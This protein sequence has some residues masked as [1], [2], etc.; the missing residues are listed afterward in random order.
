MDGLTLNPSP[1]QEEARSHRAGLF[2][3]AIGLGFVSI[4][5]QVLLLRELASSLGGN[6][7]ALGLT[8]GSW[9]LW[10]GAGSLFANKIR[11][12]NPLAP[13][14]AY[15]KAG[16]LFPLTILAIRLIRPW[17]GILP[18]EAVGLLTIL[19]T[20]LMI[21]APFGFLVGALFVLLSTSFPKEG[22]NRVYLLEALGA[23]IGGV[24]TT[25]LFIPF[26][27]NLAIAFL[28][29][30]LCIFACFVLSSEH[31]LLL[32]WFGWILLPVLLILSGVLHQPL[33]RWS[34][35]QEWKGFELLEATNSPYGAITV[36]SQAEQVSVFQQGSLV[37]SY[38]DPLSA[39]EAVHF[40]LLEHPSP[41]TALLIGN[42]LGGG[43]SEALKHPAL[44]LEYVDLDPKLLSV[45]RRVLP[46]QA[47]PAPGQVRIHLA[48]PRRYLSATRD[49]YDVILLNLPVPATAQ[50]N[51][52]YTREFFTLVKAHLTPGGILAFR[53][54]SEENYLSP[55]LSDFLSSIR[56]TLRGAFP[57]VA[58]LPGGTAIFL[59]SEA[60]RVLTRNPDSLIARLRERN[61]KTA[62]VSEYFLPDRLAPFRQER[63]GAALDKAQ[64]Q[65]NT[66]AQPICYYFDALLFSSHFRSSEKA[67]VAFLSKVP[68][69]VF[70]ILFCLGL[71]I[72]LLHG[73]SSW[74][75]LA[76]VSAGFT[77]M[78]LEVLS[79]VVFQTYSGA[80]YSGIGLLLAAF[81]VGLA[82]GSWLFQRAARQTLF[83][84]KLLQGILVILPMMF[85]ILIR[86]ASAP[87]LTRISDILFPFFLGIAGIICGAVFPVANGLYLSSRPKA[88]GTAYGLDL[89]GASLGAILVSAVF[90]PLHGMSATLLLLTFL[91]LLPFLAFLV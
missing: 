50:L 38:P 81:M 85:L 75:L 49:R 43:L 23:A 58:V 37:F 3:G 67:V 74:P 26:F 87:G 42:G 21:V 22:T 17:L 90:L 77:S 61:I 76:I 40:G 14:F 55:E 35:S 9:L 79:L 19:P 57:E 51:R 34:L 56:K 15:A 66:D 83:A 65:V 63:F 60:Q 78:A 8:L 48:D 84:L 31:S 64:A 88:L 86:C 72:L 13:A 33:E 46:K 53:L 44:N 29:G 10:T 28:I 62:F 71:S 69:W 82:F 36:V 91:A 7:L 52:F 73:H 45:A 4:T 30:S 41:K 39:E 2:L 18:G 80:L 12:H 27:P 20:A 54:P 1:V 68:L 5:G 24:L 25:F 6:E 16:V 89:L 59:A 32:R 70:A 11:W 47:P